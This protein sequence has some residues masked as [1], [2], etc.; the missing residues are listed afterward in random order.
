M[1][2]KDILFVLAFLLDDKIQNEEEVIPDKVL[3]CYRFF[4]KM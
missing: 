3:F 2:S 4:N 1:S